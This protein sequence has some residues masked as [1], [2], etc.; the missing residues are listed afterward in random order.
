MKKAFAIFL[1]AICVQ[2]AVSCNFLKEELT[3][4]LSETSVYDT[5]EALEAQV[6]GILGSFYGKYMMMGYMNEVLHSASGLIMWKG[7]R[8]Q[9]S[10]IDGLKFAKYSDVE[11]N[12]S[13]YKQLYGA[14][15]CC[16]R[17]LVNLPDSPVGEAYKTEIEGEARF[18]RA[19][20]YYYLVRLYADVPLVLTPAR[21]MA[22][23]NVPRTVYYKVY[24]QIVEDFEFAA[25][26]MRTPQRVNELTPGHGRPCNWA[27]TA[28]LSSVYM[29]IGSMLSSFEADPADQFFDP[30]KDGA[31]I[32]AGKDPRTPDFS[33]LGIS[34]AADAWQLCYN[35]ARKV[36]DEGPYRLA[37]DFRQLFRWTLPE[38]FELQER[39]F[40]L[41]STNETESENRLATYSLPPYP[42]GTSSTTENGN[43]GRFRPSRF[44]FQKFAG[45]NGGTL[46]TGTENRNI[47]TKCPDPRFDASFYHTSY[48]RS[49]TGK[50]LKIYPTGST[51]T[52]KESSSSLPYF[53]KYVD[54]TWDVSAGNADFYLMRFAEVY[55]IAAEAAARLSGGE[56]DLWWQRALENIEVIHSRARHSTDDGSETEY[57][58]WK[59]RSFAD[60][61][62]LLDAIFW[63]RVYELCGEGHEYFDTH[64]NGAK[65]LS[66]VIA[67]PLNAFNQLPEQN[68]TEEGI[69]QFNYIGTPFP[70]D[71]SQLRKSL[72]CGFPTTTEAVYNTAIDPVEDQNDFY[73]R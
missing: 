24:A 22:E 46:G 67:V 58:S 30:S 11:P 65:W 36:I 27:A 39:I 56:G 8:T 15:A 3:T 7:Q 10:Y 23:T 61:Q 47:Y 59:D 19:V 66:R 60:T 26:N 49:D 14:I 41:Q 31:L 16:N 33:A 55:L 34:N 38:D 6:Y 25:A 5:E 71:P 17:L 18:Y 48:I 32:A 70:E 35:T 52:V 63:E 72:L 68:S 21:T 2:A 40:C 42:E 4:S 54:P 29:T 44:V 64:R 1:T 12:Q 73:W 51:L 13:W 43:V 62:E 50:A 53:K 57:P 37:A 28:M 45:D 69:F 20:L 9:D